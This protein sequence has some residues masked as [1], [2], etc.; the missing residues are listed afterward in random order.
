[1]KGTKD[2]DMKGRQTE[3][4]TDRHTDRQTDRQTDRHITVLTFTTP[5][6]TYTGHGAGRPSS[7]EANK[8]ISIKDKTHLNHQKHQLQ[9]QVLCM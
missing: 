8:H 1:M 2:A 4:Q 3:R 6:L 9:L 5:F 7:H